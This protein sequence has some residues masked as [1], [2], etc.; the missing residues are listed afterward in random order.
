[1]LMY[2]FIS[3]PNCIKVFFLIK[4]SRYHQKCQYSVTLPFL[5]ITK[6]HIQGTLKQLIISPSITLF[7]WQIKNKHWPPDLNTLH[8]LKTYKNE[9]TTCYIFNSC[10]S[11]SYNQMGIQTAQ[12]FVLKIPRKYK[13][14]IQMNLR[15]ICYQFAI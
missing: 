13:F 1:M 15:S 7:S 12:L 11:Y 2:S 5:G 14:L 3:K 9:L 8:L 4:K 6:N 10:V